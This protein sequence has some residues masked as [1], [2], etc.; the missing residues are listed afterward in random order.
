[1]KDI[2]IKELQE[3]IKGNTKSKY[4]LLLIF[5]V[6]LSLFFILLS[7]S[8]Q[9]SQED[10]QNLI[11]FPRN[12]QDLRRIHSVIDRF[13]EENPYFVLISFC[14]LYVFLQSFAIPG[15]VFLSILSGALFGFIKGF[16]LVCL[17]AT[18]GACC[19]YG[20]SYTLGRG[21][22][23]KYFPDLLVKFNKK[24]QA[25]K[26]NT[27]YYMLFLRLTPLVPN[28]FVNISSPIVGI[29][30]YHFCFGTLLGLMPLN[31]VHINAGQTLSTLEKVGASF[32][33]I[34]WVALLGFVALIPTF[35][36]K[37]IE[38]YEE[39]HLKKKQ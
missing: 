7:Y 33:N 15:P 16:I 29:P 23:L 22:V 34:L 36:K 1:M 38:K 18:T 20:L 37:K 39:E 4:I 3:Q 21:I 19:C 35:F 14:Y 6:A 24:V 12:V 5:I 13:N 31:I 17:C 8:P 26:D 32:Q 10:K 11:I 25:N 28:W 9:I 2:D 30:I 27:F